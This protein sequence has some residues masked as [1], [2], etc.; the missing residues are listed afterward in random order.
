LSP[1]KRGKK[2]TE[3]ETLA[4]RNKEL[5]RENRR[6][7]R[8]LEQAELLLDIQKKISEI[9]GIPLKEVD[10]EEED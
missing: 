7:K 10:L 4:T 1:K 6:L 9:T 5:E 8:R 3:A 2:P